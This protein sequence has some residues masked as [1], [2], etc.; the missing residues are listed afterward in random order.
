MK[1]LDSNSDG[2][3]R[4]MIVID[5]SIEQ[6]A[7]LSSQSTLPEPTLDL[8]RLHPSVSNIIPTVPT[9]RKTP[10]R[11]SL[12]SYS[13]EDP[14]NSNTRFTGLPSNVTDILPNGMPSTLAGSGLPKDWWKKQES[15]QVTILGQ[16]GFILNRYMVYEISSEVSCTSLGFTGKLL[17]N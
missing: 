15:I 13:S 3:T 14:W 9:T 6:V 7:A 10:L 8:T 12:P 16:Q 5:V 4:Q 2:I 11:A 1:T 17:S